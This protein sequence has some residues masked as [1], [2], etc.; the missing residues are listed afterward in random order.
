MVHTFFTALCA[1]EHVENRGAYLYPR[2]MH[3]NS[4]VPVSDLLIDRRHLHQQRPL[5]THTGMPRP[6]TMHAPDS[7]AALPPQLLRRRLLHARRAPPPHSPAVS[8][9]ASS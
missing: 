5:T 3:C 4:S 8:L 1:P 7:P 2:R 6:P 9:A